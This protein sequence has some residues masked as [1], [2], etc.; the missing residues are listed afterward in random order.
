VQAAYDEAFVGRPVGN[1]RTDGSGGSR[2]AAS[3]HLL[4]KTGLAR[5]PVRAGKWR[6]PGGKGRQAAYAWGGPLPGVSIT[7]HTIMSHAL[8]IAENSS[9]STAAANRSALTGPS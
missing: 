8:R 6:T 3:N 4:C 1:G 2:T 7:I 5:R 9:V